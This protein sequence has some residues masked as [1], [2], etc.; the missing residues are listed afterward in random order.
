V[1][2]LQTTLT[3]LR[4]VRSNR[5]RSL[6]TA[7]GILIGVGALIL[8]VGIGLGTRTSIGARISRLGTNLITVTPG[9]VTSGGVRTGL[10]S[11]TTI[12][13]DDAAA[14]SD[15]S[16]AP[17]VAGVA[18]VVS[19]SNTIMVAGSQTWTSSVTGSTPDWLLTNARYMD[20]GN[21]ITDQDV[22]DHAHVA[23]LG[24]TTALDLFPGGNAIGGLVSIQHVPFRVVGIL[25]PRGAQGL[26]NPD[27]L[28]IVPISTA[29]G[30]LIS[31]GS[32][33]SVQRILVSATSRD[34]INSASEEVNDL[35]LQTHRITDPA[36][37][38][39]TI[40][41]QA[42]ILDALDATSTALTLLLAGVAGIS[43]LVGGIGVM[44]IMLVSVTERIAEIGL[45][46]ALGAKR[47]DILRQFLLE[48]AVISAV[49]G[50]LG[51]GLGGACTFALNHFTGLITV[52]SPP[53]AV[54]GM[55]IAAAIGL[56]FGV[57]P[58]LRA[59]RLEPI[60]ALRGS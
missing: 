36:Q 37:A 53:V 40:T 12:T 20:S 4:A 54:I 28:A 32:L 21:F 56:V 22:R 18:P 25:Q 9:S 6:L 46:K 13:M 52:F 50:L 43:L 27:D 17:D 41:T 51:V 59:A 55:L 16:V 29:Q 1:T 31:G 60:V 34:T 23:V 30:E 38:D 11:S 58:A 15:R 49:G 14:L 44:N 57:L 45:R 3:G 24:P 2:I 39:F 48:A 8:T 19:R 26:F 47:S 5:L 7:L 35:L 42:S 33:T 10:G